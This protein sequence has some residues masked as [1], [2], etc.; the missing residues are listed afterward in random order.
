MVVNEAVYCNLPVIVSDAVGASEH[1]VQSEK[2]G[3]IFKSGS[4]DSL[5]EQMV[6]YKN[7]QI[8]SE[9]GK[10]N[11]EIFSKYS[12]DSLSK[13]LVDILKTWMGKK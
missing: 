10:Y 13:H 3:F 5:A 12:S 7:F 11:S 2:N 1:L 9:H 8:I 4:S 6:K